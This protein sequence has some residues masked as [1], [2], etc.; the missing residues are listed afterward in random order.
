[1]DERRYSHLLDLIYGAMAD[2]GLWVVAMEGMADTLGGNSAWLS[3]LSVEDGSGSGL[4]ARIDPVMPGRYV[5]YYAGLN[6][7]ANIPHSGDYLSRW[8][9]TIKTDNDWYAKSDLVKTEYYNDFMR[10]QQVHSV[11]MIDLDV[12]GVETSTVNIN[13]AES[14]GPFSAD[15]RAVAAALH[16]HLIRAFKLSRVFTGPTALGDAAVAALDQST[17]GLFILGGAGRLRHVNRAGERLVARRRGLGLVDGRL[18][19]AT[20]RVSKTLEALI[21][22][23]G[24]ADPAIRGGGAM[25]LPSADGGP[26]LSVTVAPLQA[27]RWPMFSSGPSVLVCVTDLASDIDVPETRMRDLFALTAAEA[28]VARLLLRGAKPREVAA[29]TG[30]GLTTVRSQLSS[31][32]DKTG[33]ADQAELLRLMMRLTGAGE[34]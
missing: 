7:F 29:M 12:Q 18:V 16:P 11:L 8:T 19:G 17:H 14:R 28:R 5:E 23:A 25:A 34:G 27:G 9:P 15:D 2:P 33:A 22:T 30:V 13:R 10:P 31:V 32:F 1:L 24:S 20:A 21:L 3:Q 4:L 26:P 6:P